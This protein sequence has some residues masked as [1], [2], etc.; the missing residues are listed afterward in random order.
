MW[1]S[2]TVRTRTQ[3]KRPINILMKKFITSKRFF[4][5]LMEEVKLVVDEKV[6]FQNKDVFLTKL[7]AL[8]ACD[9]Q[10]AKKKHRHQQFSARLVADASLK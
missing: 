3:E 6:E 9:E 2:W 7:L 10:D 4:L 1:P 5:L 8:Q